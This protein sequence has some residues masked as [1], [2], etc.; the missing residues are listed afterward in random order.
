M[1]QNAVFFRCINTLTICYFN[2]TR[3][4]ESVKLLVRYTETSVK[5]DATANMPNTICSHQAS[6]LAAK[7]HIPSYNE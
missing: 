3:W 5:S 4:L 6:T 7:M 2:L 1:Q